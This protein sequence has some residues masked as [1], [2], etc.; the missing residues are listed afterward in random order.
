MKKYVFV[1]Q[2]DSSDCGP[3]SLSMML[4]YLLDINLSIGELR[5]IVNANSNG[6]TFNNIKFGLNKMGINSNVYG[7]EKVVNV[8]KEINYPALTQISINSVNHFIVLYGVK[9]DRLIIGDPARNRITT[10]KIKDFIDIWEPYVL[11]IEDPINEEKLAKYKNKNV[12]VNL[13]KELLSVKWHI[14]LSWIISIM[15]YFL[16]VYLAGMY[17]VFFDQVIPNKFTGLILSLLGIYM[18]ALFLQFILKLTLSKISIKINNKIDQQLIQK[19]VKSFFNKDYELLE[20]Y[21]SGELI[22]RFSNI[23]LIRG[24]MLYII[25]SFPLDILIIISTFY[26]LVTKNFYLTLLIFVPIILFI[27]LLYFSYDRI[28]NLSFSFFEENEKLNIALIESANNIQTLK[29]YS[30]TD[31]AEEKIKD[32]LDRVYGV[33]EK[34]FSFD[35]LQTHIK[36][37]IISVFNLLVFSFGAYLTIN[38]NIAS[39]V[40]LMF[41]SLAMNIFNPFLNM[42]NLQS[43]LQQGNVARLR[44]ED[45]VNSEVLDSTLETNLEE[46]KN[47]KIEN[48]SF[49]YD[50]NEKILSNINL[51][52]NSNENIAILGNSGSGKST[53][54][55]IIAQYY[56]YNVGNMYINEKIASKF[57]K[58]NNILYT[59]QSIELFSDTII[60]NILMHRNVPLDR[61]ISISKEIGFDDVVKHFKNGYNTKIGIEGIALSVGQ[62]QLL[63]ILRSTLVHHDLIIFDE[64]T[65]GLDAA[66]KEKVKSYLLNYGNMKLFITHD[67]EFAL[68][69]DKIY[70]LKDGILSEDI[71]KKKLSENEIINLLK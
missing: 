6:C 2:L 22:T 3:A 39:G 18:I 50:D 65:A 30:A 21:K 67:I 53:L 38:D 23:S 40:L 46:I 5:K 58:T 41:N 32:I 47:I 11:N 68:N 28:E 70:I 37:T 36:T 14:L 13:Y 60:N 24:R 34:F 26:L 62:A 71:K 17:S 27:L 51:E 7:C 42:A 44:Y 69:C 8:F 15:I 48:L 43:T 64:V 59:S 12:K 1:K 25:Q 61:I 54:A 29:N 16:S 20:T 66:L 57:K 45:I 63:S 33:A 55:K 9:G 31:K 35:N 56:D 49:S 4:N 52:I 19:L 10:K